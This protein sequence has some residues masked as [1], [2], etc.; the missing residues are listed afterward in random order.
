MPRSVGVD[1]AAVRR[2]GGRL[3]D[4][5]VEDLDGAVRRDL[6]VGRL[7]IAMDDAALVRGVERV[8]I[9]RAI[10]ARPRTALR[11]AETIGERRTF[12]ELEHQARELVRR[13]PALVNAV[14]VP[15]L[16]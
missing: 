12:D 1:G 15:M 9:C 7:Q 2:G 11:R 5:E 10:A 4:A 3:G 6:D 13:R 14:D 8:G 16:W